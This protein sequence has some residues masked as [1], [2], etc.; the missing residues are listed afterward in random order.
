MES[1]YGRSRT[2][3]TVESRST[4]TFRRRRGFPYVD[5]ILFMRVKFKLV[6]GKIT[7]Q[8]K[9]TF[10]LKSM[11]KRSFNATISIPLINV[12]RQDEGYCGWNLL[13]VVIGFY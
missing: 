8:W 10:T 5:S 7:Q 1:V 13:E 4:L 9:F 6:R 11:D 3:V 12:V 2:N